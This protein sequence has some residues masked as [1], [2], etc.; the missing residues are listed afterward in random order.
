MCVVVVLNHLFERFN[1]TG[2]HINLVALLFIFR[3][4]LAVELVAVF[5]YVLRVSRFLFFVPV[6]RVVE[7]FFKFSA[8]ILFF[9][10]GGWV[11]TLLLGNAT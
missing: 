8:V 9:R 1:T 11:L 7:L 3:L 2:L 4:S 10:S 5:F 6:K